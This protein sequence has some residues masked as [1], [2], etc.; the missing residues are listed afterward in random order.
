VDRNLAC[1]CAMLSLGGKDHGCSPP[2]HGNRLWPD[3]KGL[4]YQLAE[5]CL[6]FLYL[7]ACSWHDCPS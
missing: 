7:P 5:I 6:C 4:A 1:A 2:A 3:L